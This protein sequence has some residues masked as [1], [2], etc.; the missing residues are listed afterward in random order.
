MSLTLI[1]GIFTT[2]DISANEMQN[3]LI[4]NCSFRAKFQQLDGT[5]REDLASN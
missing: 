3:Q 4:S 5:T 1:A 2:P